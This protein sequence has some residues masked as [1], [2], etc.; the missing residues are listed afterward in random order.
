[1]SKILEPMPRVWHRSCDVMWLWVMAP[2]TPKRGSLDRNQVVDLRFIRV[3]PNWPVFWC[4]DLSE[5]VRNSD[6]RA[7]ERVMKTGCWILVS[8]AALLRDESGIV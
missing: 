3:C 2:R 6:E 8:S 7:H 1:M 4:H 5:E